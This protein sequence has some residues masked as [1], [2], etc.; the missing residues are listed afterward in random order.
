MRVASRK[1]S[2]CG[3]PL[4]PGG[5]GWRC[6]PGRGLRHAPAEHWCT[7]GA[8]LR[9]LL[10]ARVAHTSLGLLPVGVGVRVWQDDAV[11]ARLAAVLAPVLEVVGVL[12]VV[13]A[14]RLG[15]T[16]RDGRAHVRGLLL[17]R[18]VPRAAVEEVTAFPALRW[19]DAT[20]RH[21]WTPLV[22]LATPT[23]ALRS[24]TDHN[25]AQLRLLRRWVRRDLR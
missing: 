15:V 14:L 23:G 20:G 1:T 2:C 10:S 19:R 4:W 7:A 5:P 11:P 8:E 21:R 12:V 16:C 6:V 3:W 17:T 13:R 24:V 22:F 25:A 18:A 9:P